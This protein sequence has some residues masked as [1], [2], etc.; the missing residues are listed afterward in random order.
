MRQ[1]GMFDE[2]DRL[3]KISKLGD[4]LETLQNVIDWN[5]FRPLLNE[6]MKK[7]HRGAGED[8]RLTIF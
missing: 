1:L 4:S 8:R 5:M 6:A 7:S 2:S 3:A